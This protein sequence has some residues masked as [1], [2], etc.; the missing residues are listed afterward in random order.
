MGRRIFARE[1]LLAGFASFGA[2]ASRL[3]SSGNCE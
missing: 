2:L 1:V 3:S